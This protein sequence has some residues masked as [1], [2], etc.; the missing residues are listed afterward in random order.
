M[1]HHHGEIRSG[2]RGRHLEIQQVD[3]ESSGGPT[4][5]AG[6]LGPCEFVSSV[7]VSVGSITF[8]LPVPSALLQHLLLGI[9]DDRGAFVAGPWL[10]QQ[11][12][13]G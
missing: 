2:I 10:Q 13:V 12:L 1:L 9:D 11:E 3:G 4:A 6:Y 7:A 5:P 8:A